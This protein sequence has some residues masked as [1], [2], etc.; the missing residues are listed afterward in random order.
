MKNV[1]FWVLFWGMITCSCKRL[2]T[3]RA[4]GEILG[5]FHGSKTTPWAKK[6]TL[7]FAPEDCKKNRKGLRRERRMGET[8]PKWPKAGPTKVHGSQA[9]CDWTCK[10]FKTLH[11]ITSSICEHFIATL[12]GWYVSSH[13]SGILNHIYQS[14][15]W[16]YE[17]FTVGSVSGII[18][19]EKLWDLAKFYLCFH[20][21]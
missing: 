16:L 14:H 21:I 6:R 17:R 9:V 13:Y 7:F 12:W 10:T 20:M 15:Q 19:T 11:A 18:E 1:Y 5:K 4:G 8:F 3:Y 2:E